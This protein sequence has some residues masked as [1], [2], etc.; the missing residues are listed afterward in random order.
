MKLL[1]EIRVASPNARDTSY[2]PVV[3]D[4]T[5]GGDAQRKAMEIAQGAYPNM[6]VS[7]GPVC[8]AT[9][10]S[11]EQA[12]ERFGIKPLMAKKKAARVKAKP[13]P[14]VGVKPHPLDKGE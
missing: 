12:E 9:D 11:I 4:A 14:Q 5:D 13:A 3:V 1:A 8:P 10:L 2:V 6:L 7:G